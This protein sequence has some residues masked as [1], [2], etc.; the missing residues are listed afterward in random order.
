M[1]SPA[2]RNPLDS[3]Y[4]EISANF[5]AY[6]FNY[7]IFGGISL[8]FD[9]VRHCIRLLSSTRVSCCLLDRILGL[10]VAKMLAPSR[11]L[12]DRKLPLSYD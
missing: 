1:F 4:D 5:I 6:V 11:L 8:T 7:D 2:E 12:V 3:T 10:L 9:D